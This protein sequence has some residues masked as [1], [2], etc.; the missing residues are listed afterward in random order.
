MYYPAQ[1]ESPLLLYWHQ[2]EKTQGL[3]EMQQSHQ[4][5]GILITYKVTLL[6]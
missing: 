5:S 4:G 2:F 3:D 6:L 1:A